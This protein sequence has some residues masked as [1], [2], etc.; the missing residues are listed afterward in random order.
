MIFLEPIEPEFLH[1]LQIGVIALRHNIGTSLKTKI[2]L[3]L[4]YISMLTDPGDAPSG[5][6]FSVN[7][8]A[9]FRNRSKSFWGDLYLLTGILV[10]KCVYDLLILHFAVAFRMDDHVYTELVLRLWLGLGVS[11]AE[12][13]DRKYSP[14]QLEHVPNIGEKL[15]DCTDVD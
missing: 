10:L 13:H 15:D 6:S 4:V 8:L 9:D 11:Y 7:F 2:T 5:E 14:R 3:S 12:Q 1:K